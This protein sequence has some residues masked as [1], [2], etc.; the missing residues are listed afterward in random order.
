MLSITYLSNSEE[1]VFQ[2]DCGQSK[3]RTADLMTVVRVKITPN[4]AVSTTIGN[5]DFTALFAQP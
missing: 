3:L 2:E 5:P 4:K 1:F